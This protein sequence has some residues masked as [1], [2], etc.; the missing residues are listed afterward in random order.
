MTEGAQITLHASCVALQNA[1][2]DWRA[3]LIT[4]PAGAGKSSLALDLI[5]R[6]ATLVA[7]DRT[8]LRRAGGSVIAAC[9]PAIA[10]LIEAR[11]IGLIRAPVRG[12]APV[13][14]IVDLDATEPDRL[15]RP[16]RADLLGL[17]LPRILCA[18]SLWPAPAAAIHLLLR[19]AG[20]PEPT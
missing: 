12:D 9:P 18:A 10:G 19:G 20:A 6:G 4:G 3:A 16:R 14:L 13:A 8:C 1:D 2:G 17:S 7:D 5:S 11:G 15:P